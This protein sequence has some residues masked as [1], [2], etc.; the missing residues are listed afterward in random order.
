M[1]TYEQRL[2][3]AM[4]GGIA[5]YV[6]VVALHWWQD[7]LPTSTRMIDSCHTMDD[8]R[9][10]PHEPLIKIRIGGTD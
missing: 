1:A 9:C 7:S 3:A 2:G 6:A 5:A 8:Q 10:G 4:A